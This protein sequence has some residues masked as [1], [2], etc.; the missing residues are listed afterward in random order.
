SESVA[1][2]KNGYV[3]EISAVSGDY[4]LIQGENESLG[5]VQLKDV[6]KTTAEK[7]Y[8]AG[9]INNDMKVDIYDLGLL[10]EYLKNLKVLPDGITTLCNCEIEAADINCDGKVNE[11]DVLVYLMLICI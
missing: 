4:G 10:S 7:K 5:W 11:G 2:M 3:F 8:I 9:D 6:K 1:Q